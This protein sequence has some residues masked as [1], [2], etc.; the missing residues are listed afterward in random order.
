V[1]IREDASDGWDLLDRSHPPMPPG[2]ALWVHVPHFD[3]GPR[4]GVYSHDIRKTLTRVEDLP[5]PVGIW[6][7]DLPRQV[8]FFDVAKNFT[9]D[10]A[11]DE[12]RLE[13]LGIPD[14]AHAQ[15]F[16]FNLVDLKLHRVI[17]L[18]ETPTYTFIEPVRDVVREDDA[19]FALVIWASDDLEVV[20]RDLP[21]PRV[22][23]LYDSR[24]NPFRS[25]TVIRYD[26][27][28][29]AQVNISVYDLRGA[30]IGTIVRARQ[31]AGGYEY[32]WDGKDPSGR[33]VGQGVYFLR[34]KIDGNSWTRKLVHVK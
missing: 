18:R 8:W 12:I 24:P 32:K 5:P 20:N 21:R 34:M 28:R 27:A 13:F 15:T 16:S 26:L 33:R 19:R 7:E 3:W 25:S 30:R 2:K 10:P 17:N 31:D 23:R 4:L 6:R 9:D 22:T 14:K 1:G 11:G 29:T